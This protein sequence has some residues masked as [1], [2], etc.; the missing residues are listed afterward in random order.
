MCGAVPD[1]G[2]RDAEG[3]LAEVGEATGSMVNSHQKWA[4]RFATVRMLLTLD[5][6][7]K[8]FQASARLVPST[9]CAKCLL[10]PGL[11]W[12]YAVKGILRYNLSLVKLIQYKSTT[13]SPFTSICFFLLLLSQPNV[14][15]SLPYSS[16]PHLSLSLPITA[17][18]TYPATLPLHTLSLPSVI[19]Q[20]IFLNNK[21]ITLNKIFQWPLIA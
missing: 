21:S 15:S 6:F 2:F 12:N 8:T 10:W 18:I 11:A 9:L 5:A 17:S 20:S 14:S 3:D 4:S 7:T 1:P 16:S 19:L 13:P